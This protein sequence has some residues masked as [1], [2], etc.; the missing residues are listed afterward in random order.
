M[1]VIGILIALQVDKWNQ[2]RENEEK[3]RTILADMMVELEANK[4]RL[5][6]S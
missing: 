3:V 5:L 4:M 2:A 6:A 1:V